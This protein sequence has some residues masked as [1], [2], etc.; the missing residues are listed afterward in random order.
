MKQPVTTPCPHSGKSAFLLVFMLFSFILTI[1]CYAQGTWTALAPAPHYN[2]G[3]MVLLTDGSVLC[4]SSSGPG[5][6]N[7]W[8]RLKPN[9]TGSYAGGTWSSIA[10]MF[11][12]RLYFSSQV[13]R[14]GRL[15][16][17]GG[18]Y[19]AGGDKAEVYDPLTNTW[20]HCPQLVATLSTKI[21][22]ANSEIL[23]DGKVLQ[24]IVDTGGT[25]LNFIW[26]PAT[27]TYAP[28]GSCLRT[29]NEASWVKLPDQSILFLDNYNVTSERYIPSLGTWINDASTSANL[30]DPFGSEAGGAFLLPNGKVYF[31]GS[32]PVSA[33]YTP[34]GS[35]APG[36]WTPGPAIPG[37][38][39]APDAASAMMVNGK[40]L[41]AL[42]PPPR[43][44]NHFPDSTAFFTFDY[45]TNVYTPVAAP[46]T[47]PG[48]ETLPQPCYLTNMLCL[49][50][51]NILF[52]NQ[53]DDQYYLFTPAS[54]PLAA[55][56]P[57][58]SN[59][60]ENTC[61]NFTIT[62]TL[63]NGIS[64]GAC[65]GDDWQNMTNYPIVR[66]KSG[67]SVY[68]ARTTNW[69]STGVMR[70]ALPDTAQF[71]IPTMPNGPYLV[72]VVVNGN[73][74]ATYPLTIGPATITPATA[75][76]CTGN[77]VSMSASIAGGTWSSASTTV[78][79]VGTGG[80]VTGVS[81]GVA[82]IVYGLGTCTTTVPVSVISTP[83]PITPAGPLS[84]CLGGSPLALSDATLGGTWSGSGT[85]ASVSSS[86][87]VT[88]IATGSINVS[89]TSA[90]CSVSAPVTVGPLPGTITGIKSLC[91]GLTTAL[92][93]AGGGS[94]T[95]L[96]TAVATVGTASGIVTGVS[97]GTSV[98]T[99]TLAS[100]CSATTPVTVI[101]TAA[102]I[103]GNANVCLG[104]GSALSD[105]TPAG[106]WSSSNTS[107]ATVAGGVVTGISLGTAVISYRIASGCSATVV[108]TV[109]PVPATIIGAANVCVGSTVALS[110]ATPGGAWTSGNTATA[111]V[112]SGGTVTGLAAGPVT[113]FYSL[114][115]GCAATAAITVNAVPAPVTGATMVCSG[116]TITLSDVTLGGVWSSGNTAVAAVSSGAVTGVSA[117]TAAITYALGSGCAA[118]AVVTV[119]AS[120][121]AVTGNP[122][123]CI[124]LTTS[125][126][127][128]TSGG[129]WSSSNTS[130]ASVNS[131]GLVNGLTAGTATIS[132]ASISGCAA[133]LNVAVNTPPGIIFGVAL[134]CSGNATA[135]SDA[136]AGGV[137][138]SSNTSVATVGT[139]SGI[140]SG[141]AT[142]TATI[143]Y[144]L[145][146]GCDA[147]I[148]VNILTGPAAITG[149]TF[150]CAGSSTALSD[151][152]PGG[153]WTSSN[154]AVATVS[155]SGLVSGIAT[156]TATVS[157]TLSSGCT[158][159]ATVNVG[160]VTAGPIIGS[161]NV[162]V[163][164]TTALTDGTAGGSWTSS[165]TA[166]A[167]VGTSTGIVTGVASGTATISY[168]ISTA[169]GTAFSVHVIT[170]NSLPAVAAIT[171]PSNVCLSGTAAV[172]D[173]TPSGVWSTGNTAIAT[174][175]SSGVLSGVSLGSVAVSYTVTNSSGCSASAVTPVA[176]NLPI[177]ASITPASSTSF[178]TGGYVTL[179]ATTGTGYTYQW[180]VGGSDIAGATAASYLVNYS[181]NFTVV[182]SS[183]TICTSVSPAVA[184]SVSPAIAV[185][186][187]VN[188]NSSPGTV[189]CLI[190]SPITF[191][192][193]PT[194]GGPS[195]A[196]K[197]YVNG[198]LTS[199][200]SPFVFSP[201][202]GDVV[203]C[204]MTSNATCAFPDTGISNVTVTISSA[205]TP[206]VS[207]TATPGDTVC[208]GKMTTFTAV[209]LFGGTLP[210]YSWTKNGT[211]VGTGASY[212][213]IPVNKDLLVSTMTS[214]Y[215][216]LTTPTAVSKPFKIHVQAPT[217]NSVTIQVTNQPTN[218]M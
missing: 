121:A 139:T 93:D 194:N 25:R 193:A 195:P 9:A 152:S 202:G 165:N 55:G 88:A 57:T 216:C 190:S 172:S 68:Y 18:E 171:G 69:N 119:T 200:G 161:S 112:G 215:G 123:L 99:Y 146:A 197:W 186:P 178:C 173:A 82:N 41:M 126:T 91:A 125:L 12:D 179:N 168:I 132:Y 96:N 29:D 45:T 34:T 198:T 138:S 24:A 115:G 64:E 58:I 35:V 180:K 110:D 6:G 31:L 204:V 60:I 114:P 78:A 51:G 181:G 48:P 63:F 32:T 1:N 104:T 46:K 143:T 20:T 8:D 199:I 129:A 84:V 21:S 151:A 111:V 90:G 62:G 203:K 80:V 36:S 201:A 211:A 176:V 47:G 135:L 26:D 40:I 209:P 136:V 83:S 149:S 22:D 124:G 33:Y 75:S 59:I 72:E 23:P 5:Q 160:G 164:Q 50:D 127:D 128:A 207:I 109:N 141:V 106:V 100:G 39:G 156:G 107:V 208:T 16:V 56:K 17:A 120:P 192:P 177:A 54:A 65:Y 76:I 102:P 73:P 137:W 217:V 191:T 170:I 167:V 97:S 27:N 66:L 150:T 14:D 70:G 15:Y 11:D 89:Y 140:V 77:T 98:I 79:S 183:P 153:T 158:A 44:G 19:G 85:A 103:T 148:P 113:I 116:Q 71:T 212:S 214:N 169:C 166:K 105:I 87:V 175:T 49:P 205:Q 196:Y 187:A 74:S 52:A 67:T 61:T 210:T 213:C 95:S 188:I 163:A 7:V 118:S 92:S 182:I 162:C 38:W 13:L 206:S 155:T 122:L 185:T 94:W 189:L 218:G 101:P 28:T 37:G 43:S 81:A 42:S 174:I 117:G 147:T 2:S 3:V 159:Y 157:Y 131:L 134:L 108:V 4:K 130:V 154:T 86:G 184:V 142:G 133:T 53:G 145:G 30:Y 10:A 144:S